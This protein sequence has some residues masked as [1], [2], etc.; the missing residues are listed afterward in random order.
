MTAAYDLALSLLSLRYRDDPITRIVAAKIIEVFG[1]GA[2]DPQDVCNQVLS[3]L[4]V[5]LPRAL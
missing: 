1:R 5:P 4:G 3:E 2:D